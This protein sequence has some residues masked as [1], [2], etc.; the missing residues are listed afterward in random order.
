MSGAAAGEEKLEG[1]GHQK[2]GS[3]NTFDAKINKRASLSLA[4]YLFIY[5]SI[6]LFFRPLFSFCAK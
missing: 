5:L 4:I 6:Y 2:K 1:G 3:F